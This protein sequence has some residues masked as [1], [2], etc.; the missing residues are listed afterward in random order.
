M[1][2][3]YPDQEYRCIE[4]TQLM[5]N[6]RRRSYRCLENTQLDGQIL[7]QEHRVHGEQQTDVH[8]F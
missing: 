7:A 5:D 6:I 4:N 3:R 2:R 1:H 8:S